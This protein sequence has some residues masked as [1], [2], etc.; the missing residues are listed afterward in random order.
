MAS[1]LKASGLL[2]YGLEATPVGANRE[3]AFL[4]DPE[5]RLF[6][7]PVSSIQQPASRIQHPVSR[8]RHETR[9]FSKPLSLDNEAI[10]MQ[11]RRKFNSFVDIK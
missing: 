4:L 1:G 8:I 2:A 10:R 9:L 6:P 11:K 5:P 3:V 7:Q